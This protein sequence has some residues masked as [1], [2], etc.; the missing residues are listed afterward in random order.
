MN[1]NSEMV[2]KFNQKLY[3]ADWNKVKKCKNLSESYEIFLNKFLG[4]YD[5]FLPKK[6]IKVESK[7]IQSLWITVRI[8]KSSKRKNGFIKSFLNV[9]AKERKMN[10]KAISCMKQ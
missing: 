10:I 4:I 9:K 8:K 1:I 3:K 5:A 2:E 7:D 6:K